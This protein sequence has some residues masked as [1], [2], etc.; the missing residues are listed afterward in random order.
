VEWIPGRVFYKDTKYPEGDFRNKIAR[1][2][3]EV[4]ESAMEHT[5]GSMRG[6]TD[7]LPGANVKKVIY[8]AGAWQIGDIYG[9]KALDEAYQTGLKQTQAL[10]GSE[11]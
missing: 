1:F 11:T 7:C 4:G 9:N 3:Q 2:S 10:E 5:V 6:F 8:G